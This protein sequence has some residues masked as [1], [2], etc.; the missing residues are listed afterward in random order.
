M[1]AT[2]VPLPGEGVDQGG[3]LPQARRRA[4][5]LRR[6]DR[7]RRQE[8]RREGEER[9]AQQL[10]CKQ[11]FL[12]L[13]DLGSLLELGV[14]FQGSIRHVMNNAEKGEEEAVIDD[15]DKS[16]FRRQLSRLKKVG[17]VSGVI[18]RAHHCA[19]AI[20]T[21]SP[22][23][24]GPTDPEHLKIPMEWRKFADGT[25][26]VLF[27]SGRREARVILMSTPFLM[28]VDAVVGSPS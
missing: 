23:P 1:R 6:S 5:P 13:W 8:G 15:L 14:G 7:C 21:L 12:V 27:D 19:S 10:P 4:Q 20:Q 18:H 9:A 25:P 2:R 3:P 28:E 16:N 26:F 17:R 24:K 11:L 22:F